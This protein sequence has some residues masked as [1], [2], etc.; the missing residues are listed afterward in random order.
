MDV[1]DTKQ[2]QENSEVQELEFRRA[3]LAVGF[4]KF[5]FGGTLAAAIVGMLAIVA[6]AITDACSPDFQFGASGVAGTS[7]CLM[8]SCIAFGALSLWQ[9]LKIL[10]RYG[11]LSLGLSSHADKEERPTENRRQAEPAVGQVSPEAASNA[12]PDEPS[13]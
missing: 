3:Q 4:A 5:G 12:F 7:V 11:N 2:K 10:A 8:I 13:T 1:R 9:P 6:L